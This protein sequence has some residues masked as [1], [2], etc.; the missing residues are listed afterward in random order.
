[1][2]GQPKD[3]GTFCPTGGCSI[4]GGDSVICDEPTSVL[5]VSVQSQIVNLLGE[6]RRAFGFTYLFISHN[7]VV[8]EHLGAAYPNPIAPPSGCHFHPRC[9]KAVPRCSLIAPQA[10]IPE[11]DRV[12]GHLFDSAQSSAA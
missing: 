5:D 2:E 11:D 6:L 7:L 8:V 1:M 10:V 4:A 3:L 12:E 9:A